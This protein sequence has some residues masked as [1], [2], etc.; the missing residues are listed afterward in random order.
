MSASE[1]SRL[2]AQVHVVAQAARLAAWVAE[3]RA[4][5]AKRVLRRGDVPAAAR[6]LGIDDPGFVV[7]AARV[8]AIHHP[9][10][11]AEASGMIAVGETLAVAQPGFGR[12]HAEIWRLGLDTVLRAESPD[13][14][15]RAA[16]LVF[17]A[18]LE[19]LADGRTGGRESLER[20]V[21]EMVEQDGTMTLVLDG[22]F[23]DVTSIEV[24]L[25]VLAEF[26]AID[27]QLR[28][29]PLG[30]W[31]DGQMRQRR[32]ARITAQMTAGEV[33]AGLAACSPEEALLR[34]RP[35]LAG[36]VAEAAATELLQAAASATPSQRVAAVDLVASLGDDVAPVWGRSLL[37]PNVALHARVA[38]AD[39][40]L[41]PR[42]DDTQKRWLT[43]EY[44]LSAL[45]RSG[46][47]EAYLQV[48]EYEGMDTICQSGH[49]D[50]AA[51]FDRLSAFVASGGGRVRI[52]QLKITLRGSRPAIWRRVLVPASATL[53]HLHEVIQ[54]VLHWDD[55]HLHQFSAGGMR[56][57][58]PYPDLDTDG[59]EGE[60]RLMAVLPRPG[61]TLG[62]TYDFGDSWEHDIVLE[63]ILDA[64]DRTR[65]PTC[66]DGRRDAPV[67]D[68]T[69]GS[70]RR[71]TPFN[72]GALNKRLAK[73]A[74]QR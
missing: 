40:G 15:Q 27:D 18:V 30:R 29:T 32:G 50:A 39:R 58:P 38:L 65:Y 33:L 14:C 25:S 6:A 46:V 26:G 19:V 73:L 21:L 72:M 10:L 56:Y 11:V 48:Q 45:E 52:H 60:V 68:W 3:G 54:V 47:E 20:A 41:D 51:L 62:Y 61:T 59:D 44:G 23:C 22:W 36:R 74:A 24:A 42:L 53:D 67:E 71:S 17:P 64:D 4:V 12:D 55:D 49:P 9:W 70:G 57:S 43:V 5:T 16:A 35:W 7:S 13:R 37:T 66:V 2:A 69:P 8:A 31:A 1:A 63:A 34:A 28:L